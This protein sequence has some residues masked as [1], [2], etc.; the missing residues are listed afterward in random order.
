[1]TIYLIILD[2]YHYKMQ[3][4]IHNVQL[5]INVAFNY[6]LGKIFKHVAYTNLLIIQLLILMYK[7]AKPLPVWMMH[8]SMF[9][10]VF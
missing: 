8:M 10:L 3:H 2:H 5:F 1:M 6:S 4:G 9:L 7:Q